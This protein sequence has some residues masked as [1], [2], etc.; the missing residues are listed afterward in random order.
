MWLSASIQLCLRVLPMMSKQYRLWARTIFGRK[1]DVAKSNIK[2]RW[3]EAMW[4]NKRFRGTNM[5][6]CLAPKLIE[7]WFSASIH[8]KTFFRL[9]YGL[10]FFY[11]RCVWRFYET[12]TSLHDYMIW[13]HANSWRTDFQNFQSPSHNANSACVC[14]QWRPPPNINFK[15]ASEIQAWFK[16]EAIEI[17]FKTLFLSFSI[18]IIA[19]QA[20]HQPFFMFH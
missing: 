12:R 13:L 15:W 1:P 10:H 17:N 8:L 4:R 3:P 20:L 2:E 19:F 14:C 9:L 16:N 18:F 7:M 5:K 6:V 11:K